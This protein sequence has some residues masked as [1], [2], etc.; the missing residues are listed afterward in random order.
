MDFSAVTQHSYDHIQEMY[1]IHHDKIITY[2]QD[3]W[4]TAAWSVQ[5][6]G[7]KVSLGHRKSIAI[8]E[9][10]S[11]WS[12]AGGDEEYHFDVK[13]GAPKVQLLCEHEAIV[14]LQVDEIMFSDT[15]DFK[16]TYVH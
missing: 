3:S 9:W 2:L 12:G 10:N 6:S 7:G 1:N 13:F 15:K 5:S 8:A 4:R 16:P 11:T 14:Y